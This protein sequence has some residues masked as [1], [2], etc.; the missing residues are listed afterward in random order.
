MQKNIEQLIKDGEEEAIEYINDVKLS[1]KDGSYFKDALDW[2]F[3]RYIS[4]IC[5]R[6]YLVFGSILIGTALFYLVQMYLAA[7]P[8]ITKLPI[9]IYAPEDAQN[10]SIIKP[11]KTT[12]SRND[13]EK[14]MSADDI[15]A[16]YLLKK[17]VE[18]RESYD[19]SRGNIMDLNDKFDQIKN[20]SSASEYKNF[21]LFMSKENTRSPVHFFGKRQT[22][23]VEIEAINI[24]R[25]TADRAF[26]RARDFL[27]AKPPNEAEVRFIAIT[28]SDD[29]LISNE[30]RERYFAKIKFDFPGAKNEENSQVK[31]TVTSYKLFKIK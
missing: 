30:N 25:K 2:Y 9:A 24:V 14:E 16:R 29:G 17:Y 7:F 15:V 6:T 28:K 5:D 31:F 11:A 1:V 18:N 13:A 12:I 21:Q 8:L 20:N 22:R 19:F 3:F 4:P 10:V 27:F 26:E 23:S